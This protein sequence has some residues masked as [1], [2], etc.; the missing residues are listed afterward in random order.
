MNTAIEIEAQLKAKADED[1]AFRARL[2]ADPRDAIKEATGLTIPETF[3]VNV[4]EESATDFHIV[5]PPAG[6]QISDEAMRDAAGGSGT[7]TDKGDNYAW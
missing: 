2:L 6:G 3:N 5:L 4:H 7:Y 1:A